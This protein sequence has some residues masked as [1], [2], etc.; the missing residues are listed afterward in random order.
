MKDISLEKYLII[1]PKKSK[2]KI[3]SKKEVFRKLLIQKTGRTGPDFK[4]PAK[5]YTNSQ[6]RV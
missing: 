1:T 3:L 2:L 6:K 4:V 5:V